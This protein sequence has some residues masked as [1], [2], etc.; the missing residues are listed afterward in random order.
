MKFL[1]GLLTIC[2]L[3]GLAGCHGRAGDSPDAVPRNEAT[4]EERAKIEKVLLEVS[5]LTAAHGAR[6][7]FNKIP[8]I[9]ITEDGAKTDRG[10]YCFTGSVNYI[11]INRVVINRGPGEASLFDLLLHEIGHCYF[12]RD[13]DS[14]VLTKPGAQIAVHTGIFMHQAVGLY[15]QI[16]V[17]V[18]CTV[19]GSIPYE[20]RQYYVNELMGGPRARS[21]SDFAKFAPLSYLPPSS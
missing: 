7:M 8:V 4:P 10:G 20:L 15:N 19:G 18:M 11:A 2:A 5:D 6:R 9:V 1:L 3:T 17:S 14:A 13:H 16:C 21:V 12:G